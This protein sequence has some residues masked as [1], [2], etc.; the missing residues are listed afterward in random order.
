MVP[1]LSLKVGRFFIVHS[2]C[3]I[4]GFHEELPVMTSKEEIME[5]VH[6]MV[7][8]VEEP[9]NQKRFKN[10]DKIMLMTFKD[11]ELDVTINFKDGKAV[12]QEGTP[13]T[14][15]MK[16]IT[17]TI[18]LL[19]ILDGSRSAMRSFMGGKIKADGSPRDL[20]KLQSLLKA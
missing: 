19:G 17:D 16:I 5:A 15:D 7:T 9:K 4:I 3:F 12:V 10:Y 11:I 6:R 18:T 20:M 2:F 8:K 1:N 14:T 13:E